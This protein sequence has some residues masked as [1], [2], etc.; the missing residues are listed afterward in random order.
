MQDQFNVLKEKYYDEASPETA[1]VNKITK[2]DKQFNPKEKPYI[3]GFITTRSM[4]GIELLE[5]AYKEFKS[6]CFR[7][8]VKFWAVCGCCKDNYRRVKMREVDNQ[9]PYP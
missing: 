6:P 5:N 9:W 2:Q 4:D 3:Y 8:C 7:C 1:G